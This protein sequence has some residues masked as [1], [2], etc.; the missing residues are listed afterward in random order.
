MNKTTVSYNRKTRKWELKGEIDEI[1]ATFPPGP[2]GRKDAILAHLEMEAPEALAVARDL[3]NSYPALQGRAIRAVLILLRPKPIIE[4]SAAHWRI[5]A[6]NGRDRYNVREMAPHAPV[7]WHCA[8]QDWMRGDANAANGAPWIAHAGKAGPICKHIIAV[9]ITQRLNAEIA[10]PPTC[11]NCGL[12]TKA[13]HRLLDGSGAPFWTCINWPRCNGAVVFSPHPHDLQ[14]A[15]D[16]FR[17]AL[18]L[19]WERAKR[20]DLVAVSITAER[21]ARTRDLVNARTDTARRNT[22]N[23]RIST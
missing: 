14:A 6:Q 18:M 12:H 22:S 3:E 19:S 16:N 1:L 20:H 11:P 8:C 5:V 23:E 7:P 13:K 9:L 17:E 15:P 10:W 21:R 4:M 2:H